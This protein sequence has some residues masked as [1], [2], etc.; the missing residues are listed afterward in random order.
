[1]R[2][3]AATI[4]ILAGG[5]P[6][7]ACGSE[8]P[9]AAPAAH[10]STCA[11][12]FSIVLPAGFRCT[13][14]AAA[15]VS[16]VFVEGPRVRVLLLAAP[17]LSP[18][19]S[20]TDRPLRAGEQARALSFGGLGATAIVTA[21]GLWE[22]H[23]EAFVPDIGNGGDRL[24]A[25]ARWQA[26]EDEATAADLIASTRVMRSPGVASATEAAAGGAATA[27]PAAAAPAPAAA[28]PGGDP[29]G[30]LRH[31]AGFQVSMAAPSTLELTV[32]DPAEG[33]NLS[34]DGPAFEV[35]LYL[36]DEGV[37]AVTGRAADTVT[38]EPIVVDGPHGQLHRWKRAV[39][40][41]AGRPLELELQA[42]LTPERHLSVFASCQ[43]A[44]ACGTAEA[45]LRS[46]R[47]IDRP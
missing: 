42:R 41:R 19:D 35:H 46:I 22:S 14:R 6:A 10:R 16:S 44:A 12:V 45:V 27:G 36:S 25:L 38:S 37:R 29:A 43:S 47:V 28:I 13:P 31:V 2:S 30:W 5:L 26:A 23:L 18:G 7:A 39:P 8:A 3:A 20:P 24:L 9:P 33:P 1:M 40:I 34:L 11:E 21:G 32:R 17:N 15:P 4:A